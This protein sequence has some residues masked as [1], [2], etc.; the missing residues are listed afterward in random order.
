MV[1]R[2]S[3]AAA[4]VPMTMPPSPCHPPAVPVALALQGGGSHGAFTWGVLDALLADGRLQPQGLSGTSAGAVN[5]VALAAGYAAGAPG[6][7][8]RHARDR[9]GRL[10]HRIARLGHGGVMQQHLAD[11]YWGS[12][13]K[14]FAPTHIA[15][16]ALQAWYSPYLGNPLDWNPLRELLCEEIDFAALQS[17]R[18]PRVFVSATQV[19]TGKA[20]VF[21]GPR[22]TVDAVL[23]SACLPTLFRAVEID[24]EHYWDG[25]Y[26]ANP[27]L[28]PL[29]GGCP[30]AD[31]LLVQINPIRRDALPTG[32]ADILDRA[33]EL[34]FNASLLQ[35]LRAID[36]INRLIADGQLRGGACRAV[37]LHRIDGGAAMLDF[38]AS[39]RTRADPRLVEQLF[40]IGRKAAA[41]WLTDHF[42]DLGRRSSIDVAADYLDDSSGLLRAPAPPG[43]GAGWLERFRRW[44]R[45]SG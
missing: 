31:I 21:S 18:A 37:R 8:P 40:E 1:R 44:L 19:R 24:G 22:L 14:E 2:Q 27:A 43:S 20:V 3:A 34:C 38:P 32:P 28:A 9:L 42:D 12:L 45:R 39:G 30:T 4:G 15:R 11:L 26:S 5:A 13:P 35:Q 6:D 10:W 16:S 29:I 23:A 41:R 33:G 17:P 7:G 36:L 25:G